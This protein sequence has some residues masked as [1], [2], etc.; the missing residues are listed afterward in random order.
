LKRKLATSAWGLAAQQVHQQRG[1][2]RAVHDQARVALDLGDVAAVVVDAVAVEGE[3]AVAE[4][5][6]VVGHD[7]ALPGGAGGRGLRRRV[8]VAGLPASR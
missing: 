6:H 8:H 7:L 1:D 2:Q 3:R 5:Q 4:Q